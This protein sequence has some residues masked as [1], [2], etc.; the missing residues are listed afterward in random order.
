VEPDWGG[1]FGYAVGVFG[2]WGCDAGGPRLGG[3]DR[4]DAC[5]GVVA[6]RRRDAGDGRGFDGRPG[7]DGERGGYGCAAIDGLDDGVG[8]RV[9][10]QG[11]GRGGFGDRDR[12][13]QRVGDD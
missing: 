4:G 1:G 7:D 12:R 2:S 13:R 8:K 5:C 10:G 9:G 3:R 11:G 6:G